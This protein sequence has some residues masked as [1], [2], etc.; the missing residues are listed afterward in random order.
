VNVLDEN[1]PASQRQLLETW[2][3]RPRQIGFNA[4]RRGLQDDEIITFLQQLRRPTFFTR[5]EDFYDRRLA[6]AKYALV[7]LAVEKYEVAHFVRRLL[8]HP[9]F[10]VQ[11]K[12]MGAVVRASSA[13]IS[14]WRLHGQMETQLEWRTS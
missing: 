14:V 2:H 9:A 8:R 1:I 13:G 4:G 11:A 5:D 6:H 12:R 7:C 3:L 10:D